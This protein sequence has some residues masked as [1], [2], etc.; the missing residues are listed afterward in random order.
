MRFAELAFPTAVRQTFTYHIPESLTLVPG[1]RAWVPLRGV[2]AIGLV[3]KV[4]ETK[5]SFKTQPVINVLDP[6]PV[7]SQEL[8]RLVDW[9]STFYFCSQGEVFQTALPSAVGI[10]AEERLIGV[11][12]PKRPL[13]QEALSAAEK[14]LL[15][16][17][18]SKGKDGW[19]LDGLKRKYRGRQEIKAIA[20]LKKKGWVQVIQ[21]PKTKVRSLEEISQNGEYDESLSTGQSPH[22]VH[23]IHPLTEASFGFT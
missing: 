6:K 14:T 17:V 12:E 3:V 22:T 10:V 7:V 19:S 9:I 2:H 13:S 5:P 4:H 8:L 23:P 20:S 18:D 1:V 15:E 11:S 21:V 16:D